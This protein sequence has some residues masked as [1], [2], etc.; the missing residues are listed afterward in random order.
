ME[1]LASFST[2][3][4]QGLSVFYEITV[5]CMHDLGYLPS[6][7]SMPEDT[8]LADELHRERR[9]AMEWLSKGGMQMK[10]Q[11]VPHIL[12][13]CGI[14]SACH[15]Q[16]QSGQTVTAEELQNALWELDDVLQELAAE[17][18]A[19]KAWGIRLEDLHQEA[20]AKA[21][22]ETDPDFYSWRDA[23]DKLAGISEKATKNA[24]SWEGLQQLVDGAV[25]DLKKASKSAADI[26][27]NM[28]TEAALKSW[29]DIIMI[30]E[31]IVRMPL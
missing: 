14:L 8:A 9:L 23:A 10:H 28:Y 16:I 15:E 21:S 12:D 25:S 19:L 4:A 2:Q 17:N 11:T 1:N 29:N 27:K 26:L 6:G 30:A 13:A 22:G 5:G 18:T 7:R 20:V 31:N 3:L 24:V